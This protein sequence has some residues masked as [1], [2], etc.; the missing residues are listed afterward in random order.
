MIPPLRSVGTPNRPYCVPVHPFLQQQ[1]QPR[2]QEQQQQQS[3]QSSQLS[4]PGTPADHQRI[5]QEPGRGRV[6]AANSYLDDLSDVDC[7]DG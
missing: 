2:N 3:Q 1:Q 4:H 7:F 5:W 6:D